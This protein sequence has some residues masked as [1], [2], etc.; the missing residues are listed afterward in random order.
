MYPC[1][2]TLPKLDQSIQPATDYDP[3]STYGHRVCPLHFVDLFL[4][5][6][7]SERPGTLSSPDVALSSERADDVLPT[8]GP[9][10]SELPTGLSGTA[11]GARPDSV[12]VK[13]S[14]VVKSERLLE[15]S[16]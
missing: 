8:G 3:G 10:L 1:G 6:F 9:L 2:S 16:S 14:A 15:V 7:G 4:L 11:D 5:F 13:E 12:G